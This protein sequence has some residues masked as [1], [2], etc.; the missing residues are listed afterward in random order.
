MFFK[1]MNNTG[2]EFPTYDTFIKTRPS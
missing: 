1:N 2:S